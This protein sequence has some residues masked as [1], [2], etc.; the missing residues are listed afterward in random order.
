MIIDKLRIYDVFVVSL[1]LFGCTTKLLDD[2]KDQPEGR[3]LVLIYG[4]ISPEEDEIKIS[5]SRTRSIFDPSLNFDSS[6]IDDLVITDATVSIENET[7]EVVQ[8]PFDNNTKRY[9][10]PTTQFTIEPGMAYVLRVST[11]GK[12]FT[13]NCTVPLEKVSKISTS[14]N[15]VVDILDRITIENLVVRFKDI[16]GENNFYVVGAS[17][18][19][20]IDGQRFVSDFDSERYVTDVNGDGIDILANGVVFNSEDGLLVTTQIAH[21]DKL[22]HDT[23]KAG[24]IN[25]E[26]NE[27]DPFFRAVIPPSNI[28]GEGGY[29]VFAGFRLTERT[30]EIR[31]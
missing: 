25:R 4:F 5:V 19:Q 20:P 8:L 16:I 6:L 31:P 1:L 28:D 21:V 27:D 24:F 10:V 12:E 15:V 3:E 13:A 9:V 18:V 22:I 30:E 7:R 17:F 26:A 11:Q 29:G 14:L 23:F 2:A